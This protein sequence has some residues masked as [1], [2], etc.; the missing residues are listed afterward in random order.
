MYISVYIEIYIHI[1]W[2]S[3]DT[4]LMVKKLPFAYNSKDI[5]STF[6][7]RKFVLKPAFM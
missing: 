2:N 5:D 3:I 6:L 7:V 1:V 4:K